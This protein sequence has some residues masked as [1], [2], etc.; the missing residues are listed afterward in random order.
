M[1]RRGWKYATLFRRQKIFMDKTKMRIIAILVSALV[2][3]GVLFGVLY[4]EELKRIAKRD[5]QMNDAV[6]RVMQVDE[7]RKRYYEQIVE[8]RRKLREQMEMSKADYDDLLARQPDLV[9]EQ[10]QTVTKVV[11]EVVPVTTKETVTVSKPKSTKSTK[12]S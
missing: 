3:N 10:K 9:A 4:A 5:E 8:D 12:S 7:A 6:A 2:F 11:Q 1:M